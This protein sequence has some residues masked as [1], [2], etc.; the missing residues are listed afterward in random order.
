MKTWPFVLMLFTEQNIAPL[1]TEFYNFKL[2][3]KQK[4]EFLLKWLLL[5][6]TDSNKYIYIYIYIQI[7][8]DG[9][10][11]SKKIQGAFEKT[12]C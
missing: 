9:K 12:L 5:C 2:P 10:L 1:L 7:K 8:R 4:V 6:F 3:S 11:P